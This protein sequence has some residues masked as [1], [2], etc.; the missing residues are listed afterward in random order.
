MIKNGD[1]HAGVSL[2]CNEAQIRGVFKTLQG[3]YGNL[4][5]QKQVSFICSPMI[6]HFFDTLLK[7]ITYIGWKLG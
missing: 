6:R 1:H 7:V 2:T 3:F 4:L 5:C